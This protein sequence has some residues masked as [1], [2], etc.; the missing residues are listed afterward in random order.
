MATGFLVGA[1]F[2]YLIQVDF[3]TV[4]QGMLVFCLTAIGLFYSFVNPQ[5]VGY[6]AKNYPK[7]ITGKLGGLAT[8]LAI[9][10]G[11][12]AA[13]MGG[14]VIHTSG[15]PASILA[16]MFFLCIIGFIV[17]LFLK[18]KNGFEKSSE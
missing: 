12:G 7:E 9:F 5:A 6:L 2:T 4:N 18:P 10:G 16:N 15:Y 1:I 17:A 8:G 3:I 14:I 11:W 13:T